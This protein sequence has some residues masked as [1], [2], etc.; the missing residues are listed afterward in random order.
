MLP[1]LVPRGLLICSTLSGASALIYQTVWIRQL[2]LIIGAST[3][4]TAI[5]LAVYMGGLSLGGG[6]APRLLRRAGSWNLSPT[7]LYARIELGIA[8]LAPILTLVLAQVIPSQSSPSP[9]REGALLFLFLITTLGGLTSPIL[10]ATYDEPEHRRTWVSLIYGTNNLGAAAGALTGGL[11]LLEVLGLTF[12]ALFGVVLNLAAAWVAVRTRTPTPQIDPV[13]AFDGWSAQV[14]IFLSIAFASSV[15]GMALE[16]L[17]TRA[18]TFLFSSHAYGLAL[19]LGGLLMGLT[20]GGGGL[21]LRPVLAERP[22][23][24]M[25]C[26]FILLGVWSL[27]V[28]PHLV[29]M[30]EQ[31]A[32]ID[33]SLLT[34][35]NYI[36]QVAVAAFTLM[37]P[38]GILLG[39]IPPLSAIALAEAGGGVARGVGW[40]N[41]SSSLGSVIGPLVGAFFLLPLLGL[42]TAFDVTGSILIVGGLFIL[43][44]ASRRRRIPMMLAIP[45]CAGLLILRIQPN[46]SQLTLSIAKNLDVTLVQSLD[47][48]FGSA[49]VT[50]GS[51]GKVLTLY[52]NFQG[53]VG[54]TSMP[55]ILMQKRQY[56][57]PAFLIPKREHVMTVG[58][59]T[60]ITLSPV[61]R[62]K[63]IQ[64]VDAV[65][66]SPAVVDALPYFSQ[67]NEKIYDHPGVQTH[68]DD[69]RAWL[70]SHSKMYDMILVELFNGEERGISALYSKEFYEICARRLRAGGGLAQC[71][72]LIELP[73]RALLGV[74]KTMAS[75]FDHGQVYLIFQDIILV[76]ASNDSLMA[77]PQVLASAS[78]E[79]ISDL[80]S[81]QFTR[82]EDLLGLYLC[83]LGSFR[84]FPEIPL[85]EDDRPTME[86]EVVRSLFFLGKRK[87]AA[88]SYEI[89]AGALDDQIL[90][91]DP[92]NQTLTR[93]LAA[94]KSILWALAERA[95]GR[96]SSARMV[97]QKLKEDHPEWG[98]IDFM[99]GEVEAR[100]N[101][102]GQQLK[103]LSENSG[104]AR[105]WLK[106][107]QWLRLAGKGKEADSALDQVLAVDPSE[108]QAYE[109]RALVAISVGDYPTARRILEDLVKK[110]PSSPNAW[111]NLGRVLEQLSLNSQAKEAYL[112]AL[113]FTPGN[114]EIRNN[115]ERVESA[116]AN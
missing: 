28:V 38:A 78:S 24:T 3:P 48:S 60:A 46:Q 5:I 56:L 103:D 17:S 22:L 87:E 75:V 69:G 111:N 81:V 70:K 20:I 63:R 100:F 106:Y 92:T 27:L 99:L 61:W 14:W 7:D 98:D 104:N 36:V 84:D 53:A 94:R 88:R 55:G 18:F 10:A 66:I 89:L 41:L 90:Q 65:E 71:L 83:G 97:L 52:T 116:E 26:A 43:H 77:P 107:A 47:S 11:V 112:K 8:I 96:S 115:L 21:A 91:S 1:L 86:Y 72:S 114:P 32:S 40:V 37:V 95:A 80:E 102:T 31:R 67:A 50:S 68:V 105:D 54:D 74:L 39:A 76:V 34:F 101:Q 19:V 6:M 110:Q 15:C 93:R 16:V 79:L 51:R 113:R 82:P 108:N 62:E 23:R 2:A 35:W 33:T 85:I 30:V 44:I 12:T 45:V 49:T 4:S 64:S 9:G 57:V 42:E 25:G 73:P 13:P 58:I 59:G 29:S 109:E